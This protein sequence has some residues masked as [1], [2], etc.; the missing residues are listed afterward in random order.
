MEGDESTS[1]NGGG[2]E[3]RMTYEQRGLRWGRKDMIKMKRLDQKVE[4]IEES[5]EGGKKRRKKVE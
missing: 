4:R 1:Y 5:K 3:N 2:V